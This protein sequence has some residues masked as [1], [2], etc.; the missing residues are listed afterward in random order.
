MRERAETLR[1]TCEALRFRLAMVRNALHQFEA[2]GQLQD[3]P[4]MKDDRALDQ[5][6]LTDGSLVLT[7]KAVVQEL[8]RRWEAKD[9]PRRFERDVCGPAAK[10]V[11]GGSDD[12]NYTPKPN[13][14][15]VRLKRAV[16]VLNRDLDG[17]PLPPSFS[18]NGWWDEGRISQAENKVNEWLTKNGK[19]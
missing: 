3:A 8:N 11:P 4:E 16:D 6:G 12:T 13:T 2:F 1:R 5:G 10:H 9:K 14:V 18:V 17:E 15:L 19:V 7:L